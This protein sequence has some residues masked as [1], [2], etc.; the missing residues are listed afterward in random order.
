MNNEIFN[1]DD[2]SLNL[3]A[4]Q[5][6]LLKL[7]EGTAAVPICI[8]SNEKTSFTVVLSCSANG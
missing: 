1:M 7:K 5:H 4:L 8:I 3:T 6:E 2:I